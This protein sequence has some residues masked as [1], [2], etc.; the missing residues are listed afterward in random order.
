MGTLHRTIGR[1]KNRQGRSK[2]KTSAP[3]TPETA[4]RSLKSIR[5]YCAECQTVQSIEDVTAVEQYP[6][7][8]S[9]AVILGC[10]HTRT[11]TIAVKRPKSTSEEVRDRR[12]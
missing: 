5:L 8:Y 11:V 4:L 10:G 2:I 3:Q 7:A 6:S 9:S 1:D 12:L